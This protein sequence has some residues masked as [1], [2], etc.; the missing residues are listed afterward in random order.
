MTAIVNS[1]FG[2]EL[3]CEPGEKNYPADCQRHQKH[4]WCVTCAGF[5]GVPHDRMHTPG[6]VDRNFRNCACRLC[7]NRRAEIASRQASRP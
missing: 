2:P 1:Y 3:R 5:Y 4:Y 6:H 7:V